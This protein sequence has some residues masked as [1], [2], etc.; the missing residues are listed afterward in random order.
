MLKAEITNRKG[1]EVL[2]DP[3]FNKGLA[4]PYTERDRLGLRGL[5]PPCVR[6][7]QEQEQICMEDLQTSWQDRQVMLGSKV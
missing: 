3:V 7:M 1:R 6:T 2:N 4:F 5:L